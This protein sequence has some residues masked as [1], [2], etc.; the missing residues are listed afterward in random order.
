[1]L[2]ISSSSYFSSFCSYLNKM[3]RQTASPPP[4]TKKIKPGKQQSSVTVV[5]PGI[6]FFFFFLISASQSSGKKTFQS[7]S[8]ETAVP[9]LQHPP[10]PPLQT[11]LHCVPYLGLVKLVSMERSFP[12]TLQYP[13]INEIHGYVVKTVALIWM[14]LT[15][16]FLEHIPFALNSNKLH[17]AQN[18]S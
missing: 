17:H 15:A 4:K 13:F 18:F 2:C 7:K 9:F 16:I 3:K 14:A 11:G 5:E 12:V 10:H 6:F 1:M 8:L